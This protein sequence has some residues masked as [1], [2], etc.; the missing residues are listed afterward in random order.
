MR[1][2]G[3]PLTFF[4]SVEPEN[5]KPTPGTYFL[6]LSLKVDDVERPIGDPVEL[7]LSIDPRTLDFTV[8]LF[9]GKNNVVPAG[10]LY[11]LRVWLRAEGVDH[12]ILGEDELWVGADPDFDSVADAS[13]ASLRP[14]SGADSQVYDAVIGRARVQFI[15]RWHP[16]GDRYFRYTMEYTAN[17]VGK[18][19]MDD[20]RLRV[21]GDPR[22]V[23]FLV[24]TVPVRSVP[25]G[26]SHRLRVY[27]RVWKSDAFKIGHRLDF[28]ALGPLLVMG[29]RAGAPQTIVME[30]QAPPPVAMGYQRDTKAIA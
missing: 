9:P 24:Y 15:I 26:A 4:I 21:D 1:A 23:A 7:E 18:I 13:F 19:L 6:R 20:L 17:G 3:A 11:S 27:Q 10:C 22:R 30:V 28:Q 14:A 2:G 25:A 29:V 5:G 8:F 16:L 12:R